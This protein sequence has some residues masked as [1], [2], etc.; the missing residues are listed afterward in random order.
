MMVESSLHAQVC[1][2]KIILIFC[3]ASSRALSKNIFL[4]FFSGPEPAKIAMREK[5]ARKP[6]SNLPNKINREVIEQRFAIAAAD[7]ARLTNRALALVL[8]IPPRALCCRPRQQPKGLQMV[9]AEQLALH[10]RAFE[11]YRLLGA[12]LTSEA[13]FVRWLTA[14]HQQKSHSHAL[15]A[16][17][18]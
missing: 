17:A 1:T 9:T 5:A 18:A 15:E 11:S 3:L 12:D 16:E 8:G 4:K 2:I 10:P 7:S 6:F 14:H 13:A